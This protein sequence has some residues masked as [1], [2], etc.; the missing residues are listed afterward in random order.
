MATAQ[1]LVAAYIKY[2]DYV[3]AKE[4]ALTVELKPYTTAMA[5]IAT[6]MLDQLNASGADSIKTDAGTAY[7]S[8]LDSM[9]V[10]DRE[11][12]MDFIFKTGETQLLLAAVAKDA[13]RDYM[14]E[15]NNL[16]PP[17]VEKSTIRKANFRR[18]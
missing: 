2:R 9:K 14:A 16:L 10:I 3:A 6:A 8:E 17:G 1:E 11:A 7:V 5:T 4:L 18:S 15:H 12:L 13:V